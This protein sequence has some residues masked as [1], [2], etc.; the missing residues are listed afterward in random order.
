DTATSVMTM[1]GLAV[2]IDYALFYLERYR[3]ERR[4]GASKVEAI[5]RSG[6][7]A[8]KAVLFSGGTVLLAL[9]GLLFMP[10]TIFQGMGIGTALTVVI[11][12]GAALTLLP[13]LV[14]LTGDW[15][16]FPRFG[17]MRKLR[18]QDRTGYSQFED[19][20]RGHGLWGHVA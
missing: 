7:T 3:E 18:E 6:A 4:H 16:N 19:Q 9:L 2:G 5:E 15:I 13:A 8:G 1:I 14:R 17:L 20:Q 12:V 11:A 10:I